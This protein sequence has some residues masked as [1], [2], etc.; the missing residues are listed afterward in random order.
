MNDELRSDDGNREAH[1]AAPGAHPFVPGVGAALRGLVGKDAASTVNPSRE[2]AYWRANYNERPCVQSGATFDDY[3][4]AYGLGVKFISQYPGRTLDDVEPEMTRSWSQSRGASRLD[5][6][7]AATH[8]TRGD[9]IF[10]SGWLNKPW[11]RALTASTTA[12]ATLRVSS[13]TA[14]SLSSASWL[15]K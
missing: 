5:W 7:S 4:P 10:L 3:G 13:W 9:L 8:L 6:E 1:S 15:L 2:E 12:R 14:L 11:R